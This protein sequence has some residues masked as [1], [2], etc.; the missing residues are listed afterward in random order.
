MDRCPVCIMVLIRR[1]PSN[2]EN[3]VIHIKPSHIQAVNLNMSC[4]VSLQQLNNTP[5]RQIA[6]A[7]NFFRVGEHASAVSDRMICRNGE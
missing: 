5:S 6:I 1:S 7:T 3:T 2:H 4:E